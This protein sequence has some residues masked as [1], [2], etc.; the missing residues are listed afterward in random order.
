MKVHVTARTN[1]GK[2]YVYEDMEVERRDDGWWIVGGELEMDC[3]PYDTKAEAESDR[4]GMAR[5][6]RHGH[7]RSFWT[8][9]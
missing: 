5:F 6:F 8:G 1:A 3:G 7:K 2:S 4:V 9:R